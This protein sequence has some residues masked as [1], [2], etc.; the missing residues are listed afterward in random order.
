MLQ[1]FKKDWEHRAVWGDYEAILWGTAGTAE[2]VDQGPLPELGKWVALEVPAE[3]IG[4]AAGDEIKGFA[5]TQF[6]G[7]V[8]WDHVGVKARQ[9]QRSI[10]RCRSW[11][12]AKDVETGCE[13]RCQMPYERSRK[14]A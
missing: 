2:R 11:L 4:L 7:T 6:A 3:Q 13:R 10:R 14:K 8:T 1:Y 5:I 9:T 12:V